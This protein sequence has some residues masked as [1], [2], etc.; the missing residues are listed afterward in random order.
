MTFTCLVRFQTTTVELCVTPASTT[1]W[2]WSVRL[3]HSKTLETGI[4]NSQIAAQSA[5]QRAFEARL[6][7][8]D[9]KPYA[10]DSYRWKRSFEGSHY[11]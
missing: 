7:R 3:L 11:C 8:A 5:A 2:R 4:A 1:S 6:Q 10:P 9:L